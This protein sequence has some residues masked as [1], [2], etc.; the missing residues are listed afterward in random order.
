[1][2]LTCFEKT[3]MKVANPN[4]KIFFHI[5]QALVAEKNDKI[6]LMRISESKILDQKPTGKE[7]TGNLKRF[8]LKTNRAQFYA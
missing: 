2:L 6:K 3:S 7:N 8:T 4:L 1:M 5:R